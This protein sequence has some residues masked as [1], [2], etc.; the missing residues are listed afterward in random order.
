MQNLKVEEE[1]R[2]KKKQR[3]NTRHARGGFETS[4]RR[5]ECCTNCGG[6]NPIDA[7][8]IQRTCG[9]DPANEDRESRRGEAEDRSMEEGDRSGNRLAVQ[10]EEGL[11]W[12]RGR[13]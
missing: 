8:K 11:G 4:L 6:R 7:V 5:C 2:I 1:E 9:R 13:K 3:K 12:W 10:R